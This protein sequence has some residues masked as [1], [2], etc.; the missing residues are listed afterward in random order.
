[1]ELGGGTSRGVTPGSFLG[2]SVTLALSPPCPDPLGTFPDVSRGCLSFREGE[3]TFRARRVA[4]GWTN[5]RLVWVGSRKSQLLLSPKASPG[6]TGEFGV[7]GC[8]SDGD[9]SIRF[10][11]GPPGN[12]HPASSCPSEHPPLPKSSVP[13]K[14]TFH[15]SAAF[16]AF[17]VPERGSFGFLC[18]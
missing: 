18:C 17:P 15:L 7:W 16:S 3:I 11:W 12:S 2:V 9:F 8:L 1:M 5:A 10:H 4:G 13:T 14:K 6:W